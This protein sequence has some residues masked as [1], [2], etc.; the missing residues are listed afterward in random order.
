[1]RISVVGLGKLGSPI[2]AVLASKG[3]EVVGIDANPAFVEMINNH[4]APVEEPQLQELLSLH[5][6]RISATVDWVKAV[7]E[8]DMTTI[9]VPTPSGADGAFHNDHLL[10]VVDEA[11]RV[12]ATK[13]GYHLVVVSS[14]TMPGSIGGPIR[15]RL[16][17]ASG[18][19]VGYD[20]GL[21]YNPQFIALGDVING[22]LHPDL[23]LI[24]ESDKKA[25]NL[26]EGVYRNIVGPQANIARMNFVN[27]ELSKISV[28]TYVTMKI[29]FANTLGEICDRLEGA[30]AS[31][32][33]DAV[34]RDTRIGTKYLK[35]AVGYGGPCFPR[36]TIAFGRVAHL[37]GCTADLA[38][39][40]DTINRRQ[41]SRQTA[42]VSHMMPTGGTVAVLGLAYKPSTLVIEESPGIMLAKSLKQAGYAVVAH[43]PLAVGS[44][45][46]VLGA[47]VTL[48]ATVKEAISQADMIVIMTPWP[49]Y[50]VLSPQWFDDGR[51]RCIIDCWNQLDPMAFPSNCKIV[52]LGHQ[53]MLSAAPA[54]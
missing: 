9:I 49:D 8:T 23:V 41:V 32:V 13:S 27:A 3:Y 47:S 50:A 7:A 18:R 5:K 22:L 46:A 31:V 33:A 10:A 37:A 42:I 40:T 12:L 43:D 16:E 1:M 19:K 45:R 6:A 30:D 51:R 25:G 44:G 38:L 29:S 2:L 24:G 36:D 35:P 28:N 48:S 14:T 26:L 54:E 20:L 53:A 21:C 15:K 52:R 17:W 4:I 39:A 34:G 11:G